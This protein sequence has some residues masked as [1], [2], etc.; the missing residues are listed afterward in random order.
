MN[1]LKECMYIIQPCLN[2][3]LHYKYIK[4]NRCISYAHAYNIEMIIN[5]LKQWMYFTCPTLNRLGHHKYIQ[6]M[7]V[8]HTPML[9]PTRL[10]R[11]Y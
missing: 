6:R 11:I 4:K 3:A 7:D 8:F 10:F 5:I 1:I 2:E 9:K